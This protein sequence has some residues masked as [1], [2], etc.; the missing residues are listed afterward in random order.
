MNRPRQSMSG[1]GRVGCAV[2]LVIFG[3]IVLILF[4][5]VPVKMRTSQFFDAMS[6]Q[7]Q[8][9]SI[10]GDKSIQ[11]E[12]YQK[13]VELNL[14]LKKEDIHVHRDPSNVFIDVHYQIVIEFPGYTYVWK[15]D[16]VVSRPLFAV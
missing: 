10:K 9:G 1:T 5:V 15:E 2:W 12:L 3:V 11:N 4:K 8:F 6:E 13:A 7:A 14:P 16:Q